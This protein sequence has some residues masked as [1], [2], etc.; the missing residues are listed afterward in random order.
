MP[1]FVSGGGPLSRWECSVE[2]PGQGI[3]F[4]LVHGLYRFGKGGILAEVAKLANGSRKRPLVFVRVRVASVAFGGIYLLPAYFIIND[5]QL[6]LGKY[7]I[8]Q[9]PHAQLLTKS[10]L[11]VPSSHKCFALIGLYSGVRE[12]VLAHAELIT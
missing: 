5:L 8:L 11:T 10:F 4:A 1:G 3:G 7:L 12:K 2:L 9:L 6:S